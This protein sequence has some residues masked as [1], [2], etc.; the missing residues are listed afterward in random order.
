MRVVRSLV[1]LIGIAGMLLC[2]LTVVSIH[3]S[4][5]SDYRRVAAKAQIA[6]FL[7]ALEIYREDVGEYPKDTEGLEALRVNP[8]VS[9]W[10][11]PYMLKDIPSDPWGMRYRYRQRDTG[12]PEIVSLAGH[13]ELAPD[14][15]SSD[16]VG[17]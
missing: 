16:T 2:L 10:N 1:W 3:P 12:R 14:A 6:N 11:G 13:M 5:R 17:K 7:A 15:I 4:S 8:G 9:G